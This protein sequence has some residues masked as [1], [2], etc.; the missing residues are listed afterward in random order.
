M[1][2]T[3]KLYTFHELMTDGI[4][5]ENEGKKMRRKVGRILIPMIQR[6]YAQ[7]RKSQQ[8]IR[9]KFLQDIFNALE[10]NSTKKL[11]LNFIYGTFV[12]EGKDGSFELLDGQ[13]RLTTLFC[14]IGILKQ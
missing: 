5:M 8:S 12:E 7:G 13:Q 14:F 3:S 1:S 4:L 9:N 11:E 2:T 6:P 10:D